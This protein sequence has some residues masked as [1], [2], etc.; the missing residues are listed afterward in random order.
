MSRQQVHGSSFEGSATVHAA[1]PYARKHLQLA[2]A[3]HPRWLK[4]SLQ[5]PNSCRSA[6]ASRAAEAARAQLQARPRAGATVFPLAPG[7]PPKLA[8]CFAMACFSEA[9]AAVPAARGR[10]RLEE[11]MELYYELYAEP[12]PIIRCV[13][14]R[15]CAAGG[16]RGAGPRRAAHAACLRRL[17]LTRAASA[18]RSAAGPAKC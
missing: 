7:G 16:A 9:A 11:D 8:D 2:A 15:P 18:P 14:P 10:A 17:Q 3:G 5:V 1:Q 4:G 13:Q 12:G 6:D